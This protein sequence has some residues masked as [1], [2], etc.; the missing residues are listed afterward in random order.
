MKL[1]TSVWT[2][3]GFVLCKFS[4]LVHDFRNVHQT[5]HLLRI[6]FFYDNL[7]VVRHTV[8]GGQAYW[9]NARFVKQDVLSTLQRTPHKVA[10]DITL[11][12]TL[13][14]PNVVCPLLLVKRKALDE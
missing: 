14:I 8:Y 6:I 3:W 13:A 12:G 1:L 11:F 7:Q 10:L 5:C 4:N 9:A 2:Y